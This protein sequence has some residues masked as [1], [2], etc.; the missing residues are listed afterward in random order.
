MKLVERREALQR[1]L[2][3]ILGSLQK[4]DAS[5][6]DKNA[7]E[8]L[9][10]SLLE[11]WRIAH[12]QLRFGRYQDQP[13]WLGT[14]GYGEVYRGT[15]TD[16]SSRAQDVAI[17]VLNDLYTSFD[18]RDDFIREVTL[19]F[20]LEYP[21]VVRFLGAALS[22]PR[23]KSAMQT[24]FLDNSV[25]VSNEEKTNLT[26]AWRRI[27]PYALKKYATAIV[28]ELMHC[29]IYMAR[30]NEQ[31]HWNFR[32]SEQV[33]LDVAEAMRYIHSRHVVHLDLKPQN[34]MIKVKDGKIDGRAKINDF[35]VS[36]TKRNSKSKSLTHAVGTRDYMA[37]EMMRPNRRLLYASDVW[38][39][40][41]L[42]CELLTNSCALGKAQ[43][44]EI[45]QAASEHRL[46]LM[47][48]KSITSI[49][50]ESIQAIA[51]M[52]LIDDPRKRASFTTICLAMS[53]AIYDPLRKLHMNQQTKNNPAGATPQSFSGNLVPHVSSVQEGGS[54]QPVGYEIRERTRRGGNGSS[55]T[56]IAGLN[57]LY[58]ALSS[59][60]DSERTLDRVCSALCIMLGETDLAVGRWV[61]W[62]YLA[63]LIEKSPTAVSFLERN[64]DVYSMLKMPKESR[65]A[66]IAR[67]GLLERLAF[68]LRRRM[69]AV[70][71]EN[72]GCVRRVDAKIVRILFNCSLSRCTH[73][74]VVRSEAIDVARIVILTSR[75]PLESD[76]GFL[77]RSE[78][79][80]RLLF[81]CIKSLSGIES[82][83]W[84]AWLCHLDVT[85][86][87]TD[88]IASGLQSEVYLGCVWKEEEIGACV[89]SIVKSEWHKKLL[90]KA[91]VIQVLALGICIVMER[92]DRSDFRK[93]HIPDVAC[94]FVCALASFDNVEEIAQLAQHPDAGQFLDYLRTIYR[95]EGVASPVEVY[96]EVQEKARI[97][98]NVIKVQN[99]RIQAE[100][101]TG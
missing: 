98:R 87:I 16:D 60:D 33:L 101:L 13:H 63:V 92:W 1:E 75:S 39:F 3:I 11:P 9:V 41:V 66:T 44:E 57:F 93:N 28:T 43:D 56:T 31:I 12:T 23:L 99:N 47:F 79:E 27:D 20:D 37:P 81:C 71:D 72:K 17:K 38:S 86:A 19:L 91:E 89:L 85:T 80:A 96:A 18:Q 25:T 69:V 42:V 61:F 52:C 88:I 90:E 15:Y 59:D 46:H 58:N 35:G 67:S 22:E 4:S 2:E 95:F 34:I 54:W 51:R 55:A 62:V 36:Q 73:D 32:V 5:Q 97:V 70:F 7:T 78:F 48:S 94:S 82:S 26:N 6:E 10:Q 65:R 83:H 76:T 21:C 77:L 30:R 84:P 68:L 45:I 50:S 49:K 29:N 14:G 24:W 64:I 40:G 53:K 74:V 100:E 8:T